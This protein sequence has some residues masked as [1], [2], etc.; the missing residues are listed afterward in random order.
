MS[1]EEATEEGCDDSEEG[2]EE[3]TRAHRCL[4]CPLHCGTT[5][6]SRR[7]SSSPTQFP[8]DD[9]E[10]WLSRQG[11]ARSEEDPRSAL[12]IHLVSPDHV[13]YFEEHTHRNVD[14]DRQVGR[15]GL[16]LSA[17]D[18]SQIETRM[19]PNEREA[20]SEPAASLS[21]SRGRTPVR[22]DQIPAAGSRGGRSGNGTSMNKE[23]MPYTST[24]PAPL[25][26]P[27]TPTTRG[28]WLSRGGRPYHMVE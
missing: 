27:R 8:F 6:L 16:Q 26:Q 9:E 20:A 23:A 4:H 11:Q 22:P 2:S 14:H 10:E 17:V 13:M 1:R 24:C 3:D 15:A 18:H 19:V 12:P 28:L 25:Q 7:R 21:H 5:S